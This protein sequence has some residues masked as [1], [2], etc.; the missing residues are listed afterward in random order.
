VR[1]VLVNERPAAVDWC[2]SL[3]E[4]YRATAGTIPPDALEE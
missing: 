1:G 2:T 4:Q 3:Y